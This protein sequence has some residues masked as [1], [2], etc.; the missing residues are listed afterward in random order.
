M[1]VRHLLLEHLATGMSQ[2]N[3]A[4]A[5]GV[6]AGLVSQLLADPD[7][8][9][10]VAKKKQE[11]SNAGNAG[12]EGKNASNEEG[13]EGKGNDARKLD[14][15]YDSL[16]MA[17]LGKLGGL[18]NNHNY[19]WRPAELAGIVKTLNMARRRAGPLSSVA[20]TA[21]QTTV[22][23]TVVTLNLPAAM[24]KTYLQPA[25]V[26]DAGK[27]QVIEVDGRSLTTLDSRELLN[28]GTAEQRKARL[29]AGEFAYNN[30]ID[31]PAALPPP[32]DSDYETSYATYEHP[33]PT[34][35][36]GTTS[37]ATSNGSIFTSLSR[38]DL[39]RLLPTAKAP[40]ALKGLTADDF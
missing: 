12:N 39:N 22:L 30:N 2:E 25:Y 31:T 7:F 36:E 38:E 10:D 4:R 6:T 17:V 1:S 16:E 18:I 26:I 40:K 13:E 33:S 27:N 11:R 14:G 35:G 3:A 37:L 34:E 29:L 8:K 21:S 15:T 23:N 19:P 32:K 24:Q 9:A 28:A 5:V 20:T